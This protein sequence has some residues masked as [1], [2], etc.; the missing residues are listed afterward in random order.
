MDKK[1][2]VNYTDL[3]ALKQENL[4]VHSYLSE[5]IAIVNKRMTEFE[6]RANRLENHCFKQQEPV[7]I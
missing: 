3:D 7:L 6:V 5:K 2:K 1:E 4:T